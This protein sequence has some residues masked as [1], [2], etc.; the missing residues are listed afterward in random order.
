MTFDYKRVIIS[1]G[2]KFVCGIVAVG[3]LLGIF[4]VWRRAGAKEVKETIGRISALTS[5]LEEQMGQSP[6]QEELTDYVEL[7]KGSKE[8]RKPDDVQDVFW[9]P[10]PKYYPLKI[11]GTNRE[12]ELDFDAPMAS[13]SVRVEVE[14]DDRSNAKVIREV[15][16]PVGM[17][18]SRVRVNTGEEGFARIVGSV[19][20]KKHIIPVKVDENIE[21][22]PYPPLNLRVTDA[23]APTEGITIE[24]KPNPR[25]RD[26][27]V[28][29]GYELFRKNIRDIVGDF[30]KVAFL[31]V[32]ASELTEDARA[33]MNEAGKTVDSERDLEEGE[34][35]DSEGTVYRWVDGGSGDDGRR[36][37]ESG[38]ESAK[39]VP[40]PQPNEVYLYKVRTVGLRSQ[41]KKSEFSDMAIGKMAPVMDFRFTRQMGERV[42]FEIAVY[43]EDE[44]KVGKKSFDCIIGEEIGGL[45]DEGDDGPMRDFLTGCY[46]LDS[47]EEAMRINPSYSRGRIVYTNPAGRVRERWRDEW[48][49]G[50][51]D[52]LPWEIGKEVEEP[53]RKPGREEE[54]GYEMM[55]PEDLPP[56]YRRRP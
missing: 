5:Q 36:N 8:I 9:P 49:N 6:P 45:G 17:Y 44:G 25:N 10:F 16:H 15:D 46:L 43:D 51:D 56:A 18:Y 28:V 20:M 24:F 23:K 50:S 21:V 38:S 29:E 30:R 22:Q 39:A 52:D 54:Q 42:T 1:H 14:G 55:M 4:Y 33:I 31:P 53:G 13:G 12:Y 34:G 7:W 26:E 35:T 47:H 41:P 11:L 32:K 2:E 19:G 3:L 37:Q 40:L 48:G 27:V